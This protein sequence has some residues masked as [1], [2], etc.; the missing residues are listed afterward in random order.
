MMEISLLAD[1]F[2]KLVIYRNYSQFKLANTIKINKTAN[3][4][5]KQFEN[6]SIIT[7]Y[8]NGIIVIDIIL[9]K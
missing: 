8:S 6:K 9:R 5:I 7:D 3:L 4:F 1:R 2:G